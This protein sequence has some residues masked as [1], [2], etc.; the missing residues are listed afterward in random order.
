MNKDIPKNPGLRKSPKQIAKD[1]RK[2]Y[3]KEIVGAA[4]PRP[5]EFF[6]YYSSRHASAFTYCQKTI[7][8]CTAETGSRVLGVLEY[9]EKSE[10]VKHSVQVL[11]TIIKRKID[12][13][14]WQGSYMESI[15]KALQHYAS[16]LEN[17]YHTD[18]N[19][20]WI[21]FISVAINDGILYQASKFRTKGY[22]FVDPNIEDI[23][24]SIFVGEGNIVAGG[25][26]GSNEGW[27]E[28]P[29]RPPQGDEKTW[30]H[31]FCLLGF[32]KDFVYLVNS[33][34][35]NWGLI[36]YLKERNDEFGKY[37]I[38]GTKD[39]HDLQIKGVGRIGKNYEA[40]LFEGFTFIDLPNWLAQRTKMLKT[41]KVKED[42]RIYVDYGDWYQWV[43]SDRA[44]NAGLKAK[45]FPPWEKIIEVDK[46]DPKKIIGTYNKEY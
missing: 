14:T 13:A 31:A 41:I 10:L 26:K 12:K 25:A 24:Q 9:K 19:T 43:T 3:V 16:C 22:G 27:R 23:K 4:P 42:N 2:V 44:Y 20:N 11:M 6:G 36:L 46:I 29:I 5:D 34:G 15:P 33:W 32:D 17:N 21:G 35:E 30:G 37:Y 1:P 28:D 40:N 18:Y 8:S 39:N 7:P 45:I 38:K